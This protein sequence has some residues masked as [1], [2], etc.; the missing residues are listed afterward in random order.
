[1]IENTRAVDL[2]VGRSSV[3][4]RI[5]L[6]LMVEPGIRLHLRE[7]QRR[8]GT[9]PGTASRELAKLLA[10]GLVERQA[11][12]NQVYFRASASPFATMLR[13][14]IVAMPAP[15]IRPRPPRLPRSSARVARPGAIEPQQT[16]AAEP[17][18]WSA[19]DPD[20]TVVTGSDAS[21]AT[22]SRAGVRAEAPAVASPGSI[23]EAPEAAAADFAMAEAAM[24]GPAPEAA[25]PPAPVDVAPRAWRPAA[26]APVAGADPLGLRIAG[27]LA[28][29]VREIY[30]ESLKG[31]Y[32]Y[33]ARAAGPAPADADVETIVVLDRVDHYGA[34]LERTSHVC[35]ALSHEMNVVVSRVFVSQGDWDGAPDGAAPAIRSEAVAV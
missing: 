32:L 10:A 15:Q 7:I 16:S 14:V 13:S 1:M 4:Q 30:G 34:E 26:P 3:R 22:K 35:A 24:G 29:S 11:E 20:E 28:D 18:P 12:G 2:A 23:P 5:L 17:Q 6:L 27:R 9:S 8:A 21:T 19:A 33:G 31:I 25:E